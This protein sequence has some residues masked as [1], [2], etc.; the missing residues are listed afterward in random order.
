[1]KKLQ[2]DI[3]ENFQERIQLRR[4]LLELEEQN[5]LNVLEIK[6]RQAEVVVW[7]KEEE[8]KELPKYE[9]GR[10]LSAVPSHIRKEFKDIQLLKASTDKNSKRKEMMLVQLQENMAR[11]KGI[12]G[13]INS[14]IKFQEKRNF[15]ELLIKSHILEQTN[16]ELELQLLIQEKTIIDLQSLILAQKKLLEERG[17]D[18]GSSIWSQVDEMIPSIEKNILEEVTEEELQMNGYDINA[19]L[20]EDEEIPF[21]K[22]DEDFETSEMLLATS[23]VSADIDGNVD[24]GFMLKGK[25]LIKK[26]ELEVKFKNEPVPAKVEVVPAGMGLMINGKIIEDGLNKAS[27]QVKQTKQPKKVSGVRKK[28]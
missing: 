21:D 24:R 28:K 26:Q 3:F 25:A 4:A 19:P 8:N 23:K 1:M 15:V 27:Q 12:R 14:R 18:D 9:E 6:R 13:S 2:A 20:D 10:P 17:I 7:K 16:V 11:G 5:A 22:D